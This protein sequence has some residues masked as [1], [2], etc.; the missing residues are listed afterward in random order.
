M[1]LFLA[2]APAAAAQADTAAVTPD[3]ARV[4]SRAEE[5]RD[6]TV[7]HPDF[8]TIYPASPL[9][10]PGHW[11]VRAAERLEAAGLAPSYLPAQ[12]AVPRAAAMAALLEAGSAVFSVSAHPRRDGWGALLEGWLE[13]FVEE[14]PEYGPAID[15]PLL[16]G[17]E[18]GAG[19]AETTGVLSPAVGYFAARQDP[20]PVADRAGAFGRAAGGVMLGTFAVAAGEVA[21]FDGEVEAPRWEVA[22]GARGWQL[23]AGRAEVRYGPGRFGGVSLSPRAPLPRVELQRTRP[24]RLPGFLRHA[25]LVSGHLFVTRMTDEERHPTEPWMFG[26]R[27]AVR[28]HGRL[29]LAINRAAIFGGEGRPLTARNLAGLAI[30][31]I[32]SDFE[33]QILSF[34]ARWRLP[35][36]TLLP[37]TVYVEWGADDGAGALNE[38]P[39]WVAGLALPALPG[40]PEVAAGVEAARFAGCCGHGAWYFNATFPGNWARGDQG[41][42]HPLGGEGWERAAYASADLLRGRLRLDGRFYQRERTQRSLVEVGGGNLFSPGRT[43]RSDGGEVAAALRMGRAEARAAWAREAG[44]GWR[45]QA[46]TAALSAFF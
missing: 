31:V 23:S 38:Q 21:F 39:G 11:A 42:G 20:R 45:E 22:A 28:P 24:L 27:L 9:L 33:N 1:A 36:E 12:G 35:T 15:P 10:P 44:A 5:L 30:G 25:G 34:D 4:T 14:F 7:F 3:S 29:T 46:L 8:V 19:Y 13:R 43:G 37:A 2:W 16:L 18:V 26:A 41:L 17:A 40:V 6:L 32:R